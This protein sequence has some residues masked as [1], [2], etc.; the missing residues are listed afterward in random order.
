MCTKSGWVSYHHYHWLPD[1][2][3]LELG[4]HNVAQQISVGAWHKIQPIPVVKC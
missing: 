1:E 3:A 4:L 2:G